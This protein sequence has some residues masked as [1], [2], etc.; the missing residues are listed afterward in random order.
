L[1][2]EEAADLQLTK[3]SE[4][5]TRDRTSRFELG[6]SSS[7]GIVGPNRTIVRSEVQVKQ[8]RLN[9]VTNTAV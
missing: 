2:Q 4:L 1:R 7:A 3:S 9:I 8:L 5:L 6:A